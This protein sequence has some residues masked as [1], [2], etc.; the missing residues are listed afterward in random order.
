LNTPWCC[1]VR[2]V[3]DEWTPLCHRFL[4]FSFVV[5]SQNGLAKNAILCAALYG[6]SNTS[7]IPPRRLRHAILSGGQ[8]RP[9]GPQEK[10]DGYWHDVAPEL[11][12][13]SG[14]NAA[15]SCLRR[16]GPYCRGCAIE[17]RGERPGAGQRCNG[18]F[19]AVMTGWRPGGRGACAYV[20]VGDPTL[21]PAGEEHWNTGTRKL[22]QWD[23]RGRPWARRRREQ[24]G[25][26]MSDPSAA[27]SAAQ[28]HP[29]FC[30]L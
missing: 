5:S 27:E 9:S 19:Q 14:A 22:E 26:L 2:V 3:V 24:R 25:G 6:G 17:D 11:T 29:H 23:R 13:A 21:L 16:G 8:S 20:T 28:L 1:V 30:I 7:P 12:I 15:P 10:D 18:I 4:H